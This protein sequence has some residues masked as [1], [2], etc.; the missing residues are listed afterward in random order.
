MVT[1]EPLV[2]RGSRDADLQDRFQSLSLQIVETAEAMSVCTVG[3]IKY[4]ND[5]DL[6]RVHKAVSN[7][8]TDGVRHEQL[9]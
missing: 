4:R 5:E 6:F 1:A 3:A 8:R 7:P 2:I 9:G